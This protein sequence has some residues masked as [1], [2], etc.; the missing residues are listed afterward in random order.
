MYS[1]GAEL[2]G[3]RLNINVDAASSSATRTK[4]LNRGERNP[5]SNW[6]HTTRF[7]LELFHSLLPS[8]VTTLELSDVA[9]EDCFEAAFHFSGGT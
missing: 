3:Q 5:A 1:T 7:G 9:V 6:M 4:A 8:L 2:E